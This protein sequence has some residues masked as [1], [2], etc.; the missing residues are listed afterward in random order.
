MEEPIDVLVVDDDQAIRTLWSVIL[1]DVGLRVEEAAN[2]FAALEIL[3]EVPV[4]S[5]V[6]DIRMPGLD[7]FGVLDRLDD[8]PPV[9]L[10]SGDEY[11]VEVMARHDKIHSFIL[12]P[13]PPDRLITAVSAALWA[14]GG[15][16]A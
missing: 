15:S 8:P 10:V 12:K 16:A 1:R 9:I 14:G 3:R 11:D 6:L 2:G 5:M 4:A 13:V 7:G